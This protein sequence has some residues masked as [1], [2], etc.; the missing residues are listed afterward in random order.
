MKRFLTLTTSCLFLGALL[1]SVSPN[2]A[3]AVVPQTWQLYNGTCPDG[4]TVIQVC[5]DGNNATCTP[6]GKCPSKQ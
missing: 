4:I 1:L 2:Q 3:H 6:S 5:G